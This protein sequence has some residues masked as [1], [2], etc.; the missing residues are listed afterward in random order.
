MRFLTLMA[1]VLL[2][3]CAIVLLSVFLPNP[4]GPPTLEEI[5]KAE[6]QF[7]PRPLTP[8]ELESQKSME[9]QNR[10]RAGFESMVEETSVPVGLPQHPIIRHAH[11]RIL[12]RRYQLHDLRELLGHEESSVVVGGHQVHSWRAGPYTLI[13]TSDTDRRLS[14][15]EDALDVDRLEFRYGDQYQ[16]TETVEKSDLDWRFHWQE[17]VSKH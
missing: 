17:F 10:L 14:R 16:T 3:L 13:A 7:K 12:K 11:P 6:A 5:Q 8:A 2:G 9:P 1:A 15:D 4:F